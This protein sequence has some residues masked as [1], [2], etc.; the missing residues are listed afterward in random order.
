[1]ALR[2]R[3]TR[4]GTTVFLTVTMAAVM[5]TVGSGTG[6][7][8]A[9]ATAAAPARAT[10]TAGPAY[11]KPGPYAAG[12]TTLDLPDRKVEVWYPAKKKA[13]KG[14]VP[15][16]FDLLD[17]VPAAIKALLPAGTDVTYTTDA[18]RDIPAA[19]KKGGF[20]LVLMAHGTAGYREQLAY[21]GEHLASWGF[22]VASPDI[23]E[24]SLGALLGSPPA[25]PNP[26]DV[27]VMR[28]TEALLRTANTTTGGPLAGRVKKDVVAVTGQSAGGSTAIRFG[29]EP[30]VVSAIP[31]SAS[32]YSSQTGAYV[33]FP[34]APL[35]FI[36]GTADQIVPVA[37]VQGGFEKAPAPARLVTI[38]G[39]GHA[40]VAGVCPIGGQG[41]LVG[42]ANNAG[43]PVPDSLKR[44]AADGCANSTA[45]PDPSWGPIRHAVTAELRERFGI[46][47]K[48]VGL[49]Q[50]TM[51]EFAPVVVH[52]QERL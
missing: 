35:M 29:S 8:G 44:L 32:G 16:T 50:K 7:A 40:S 51:D 28:S 24:R 1:M 4:T 21:L 36:T 38:D 52:Y 11:A 5:A 34:D 18:Y 43:L 26:D 15:A 42:V 14:A 22:V 47:K 12:V 6:V 25:N 49:D 30:G 46:D 20:P 23:L 3:L 19:K 9:A 39:A 37:N 13:A 45:N 41:G 48:P 17:K 31:I 10:A 33:T 2:P 27:A